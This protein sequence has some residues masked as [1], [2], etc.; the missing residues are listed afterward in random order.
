MGQS[1]YITLTGFVTAEPKTGAH[2]GVKDAGHQD[3]GG[4]DAPLA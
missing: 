2:Q 1:N 4:L 3:P